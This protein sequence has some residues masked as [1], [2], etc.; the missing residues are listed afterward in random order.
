LKQTQFSVRYELH[1]VEPLYQDADLGV[2]IVTCIQ[3][4]CL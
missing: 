4:F 1:I 2:D 3:L